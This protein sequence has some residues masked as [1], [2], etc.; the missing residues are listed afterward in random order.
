MTQIK[1][2]FADYKF[3]LLLIISRIK[4]CVHPNNLRY[5]RA[6]S[7]LR[8]PLLTLSKKFFVFSYWLIINE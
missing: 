8:Q 6:K 5:L 3:V 1:Q 4:I 7:L 2:I